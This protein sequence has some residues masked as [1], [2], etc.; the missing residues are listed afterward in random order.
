MQLNADCCLHDVAHATHLFTGAELEALCNEAAF[1]AIREHGNA[2]NVSVTVARR[3]FDEATSKVHRV[4]TEER[5][6]FYEA[7]RLN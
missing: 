2:Q 1:A 4:L 7:F 6:A 5:V 3:H